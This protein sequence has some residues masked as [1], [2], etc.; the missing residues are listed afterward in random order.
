M[1]RAFFSSLRSLNVTS[2]LLGHNAKGESNSKTELGSY[3]F[4]T[5][6][7]NIWEIKKVQEMGEDSIDVALFHR[8]VY[9]SQQEKPMGFHMHFKEDRTFIEKADASAIAEFR[10]Q[11]SARTRVKKHLLESGEMLTPKEIAD[12]LEMSQ[13]SVR[14]AL[15]KLKSLEQV[16]IKDGKYGCRAFE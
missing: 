11:M 1:P 14:Q 3:V 6:A 5:T 12:Q 8:K 9:F 13:N 10:I 16:I 4:E 7:R 2:L 15:Y